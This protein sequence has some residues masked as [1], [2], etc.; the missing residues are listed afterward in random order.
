[1]S[2]FVF[3]GIT[4]RE[5][6]W[7]QGVGVDSCIHGVEGTGGL[8]KLH[9]EELYDFNTSPN[10]VR[11]VFTHDEMAGNVACMEGKQIA[12]KGLVGEPKGKRTLGECKGK[13][14]GKIKM[15]L[16]E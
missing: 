12:Y 11:A 3:K 9:S 14:K 13:W 10:T 2:N 1:V 5:N 7:L 6:V 8:T 16:K 15:D 4:Q